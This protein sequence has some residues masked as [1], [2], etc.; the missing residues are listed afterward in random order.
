MTTYKA[1]RKQMWPDFGSCHFYYYVCFYLNAI[2]GR[3]LL[4]ADSIIFPLLFKRGP[5]VSLRHSSISGERAWM[6]LR[7]T[8]PGSHMHNS[9]S[10]SFLTSLWGEASIL[11]SSLLYNYRRRKVTLC[12]AIRMGICVKKNMVKS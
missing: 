11:Y 2:S 7:L 3:N 4:M 12:L 9:D 1:V 6:G 8:V 10:A 5:I